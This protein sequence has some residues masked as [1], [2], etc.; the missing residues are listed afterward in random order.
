MQEL[1]VMVMSHS[2]YLRFIKRTLESYIKIVPKPTCILLCYDNPFTANNVGFPLNMLYPEIDTLSLADIHLISDKIFC[3]HVGRG[4]MW[5]QTYGAQMISLYD[6]EYV[7]SINGDCILEKP[8]SLSI[9]IDN[10]KT[11]NKDVYSYEYINENGVGTLC[12]LA[13]TTSLIKIVN[14]L[15]PHYFDTT[16]QGMSLAPEAIF[17][18]AIFQQGF[19]CLEVENPSD[20]QHSRNMK[21]TWFNTVGLRHLHG[22]E[23]WR[24]GNKHPPY[25]ERFYDIRYLPPQQLKALRYFWDTGKTDRLV[26]DLYWPENPVTNEA[27]LYPEPY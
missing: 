1:A 25:P 2:G 8:E 16:N 7:L 5:M 19:S 14:F 22:G 11:S 26:E 12:Y 27:E 15:L 24:M 10:L 3:G 6:T 20:S 4:W 13:K 18:H 9:L 17:A 23:K 21:G